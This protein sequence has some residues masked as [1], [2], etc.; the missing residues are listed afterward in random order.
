MLA[1]LVARRGRPVPAEVILDLVWGEAAL[2]LTPATVHTVVSRL[3]RQL[4][5]QLVVTTDAGYLVPSEAG[6]DADRFAASVRET[7]PGEDPASRAA[8][9]REALGE[10]WGDTA[11][12]GVPDELVLAERVR[13]E[14][15]RRRARTELAEILVDSTDSEAVAEALT[16]SLELVAE[17]PLDESAAVLAMRAADRLQRPAEALEIYAGLQRRLRDELGVDPGPAAAGA[18]A[19]LLAREPTSSVSAAGRRVPLGLRLPAPTSPVVGRESQTAEVVSLLTDG[20]RLVTITGIG[21]VG[22]SRLLVEV[23]AALTEATHPAEVT[24][25]SLAG[26][27]ERDAQSLAA[28]IAMSWGLPVRS[29]ANRQLAGHEAGHESGHESGHDAGDQVAGLVGALRSADTTVLVDE[30]EWALAPVAELAAAVL[31]GC[32]GI[33]LVV[34]SRAPLGVVGERVFPL[35]P[36]AVPAPSAAVEAMRSAPAV[37]LLVARLADRGAAAS[38]PAALSSTELTALAEVARRLDGLPLALE[39]VAAHATTATLPDLPDLADRPL[40]LH[41]REVGRDPR[42]Q[43]LRSTLAWSVGRLRPQTREALAALAVFADP[44]TPVAARAVCG[45]DVASTSAALAELAAHHVVA[46]DRAGDGLRFRLLHT[47]RDYALELLVTTGRLE[48]VRHRHARWFAAVWRDSPLTDELVEH[49]GRTH[50]DHLVALEH[51][52]AQRDADAAADVCLALGRRWLF[53]EAHGPGLRWTAEVLATPALCAQQWARLRIL[54]AALAQQIDWSPDEHTLI[55]AALHDD[56]DWTCQLRLMSAIAS[57]DGGEIA[58]ARTHLDEGLDVARARAPHHVA[59]LVATRA[60]VD[61]AEGLAEQ[62]LAGAREAQARTSVDS[63]Q[64]ASAV[65]LLTVLPKV[66]VALLDAGRPQEAYDVLD[67]AARQAAERFGIAATATVA[68]NAGWAALATGRPDL[69]S[70]WFARALVGP[71]A[72]VAPAAIGEAASGAGAALAGTRHPAAAELL[73]I[74]QWLLNASGSVLAPSLARH[75][76][77]AVEIAG[78]TPPPPSWSAELAFA[79]V[80]QLVGKDRS[81]VRPQTA[82]AQ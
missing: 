17:H 47:V 37:R 74:G 73:G 4:G 55:A 54:R 34:A 35:A 16:T 80:V 62:A 23:G 12:S 76:A 13:L 2:G 21:G 58:A 63:A 77:A 26:R 36:L 29:P 66:G 24:Y 51:L 7:S 67:A 49:V 75:V 41:S 79:R 57:Y 82:R 78:S 3:R 33:R 59:E 10:W 1:V 27:D 46:L 25:V 18:H 65:E 72:F 68:V 53:V 52:L 20:H 39:L 40:E 19:R 5:E 44:F 22:K 31:A 6:I 69:A 60:V 11:Y 81:E 64:R 43:S 32:P 15:L 8:R 61:A 70:G 30:A 71:Q 28:G 14:E 42:Q 56:P 50:H 38:D 48:R 45:L 9:L